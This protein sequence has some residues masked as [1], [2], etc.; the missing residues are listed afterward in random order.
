MKDRDQQLLWEAYVTEKSDVA[1]RTPPKDKL[2][3]GD[4]L[5]KKV[6][7][8]INDEEDVAEEG[9]DGNTDDLNPAEK[10]KLAADAAKKGKGPLKEDDEVQEEGE[11]GV[12][13][14]ASE[15]MGLSPDAGMTNMEFSA[16]GRENPE[17]MVFDAV[18]S[19]MRAD[20]EGLM[21][22]EDYEGYSMN[23]AFDD[24]KDFIRQSL[25]DISFSE[26]KAHL[27]DTVDIGYDS[28]VTTE[29]EY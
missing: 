23:T 2:N 19:W 28:S 10:A 11:M 25:Q 9:T 8:E 14:A 17:Q 1:E 12:A 15:G 27:N 3:K 20:T 4:F 7:D 26:I 6:R 18:L 5:P 24:A 22:P 13:N 16:A 29:E 21:T